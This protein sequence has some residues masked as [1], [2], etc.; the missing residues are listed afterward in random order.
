MF[1]YKY[2][3]IVFVVFFVIILIVY[4]LSGKVIEKNDNLLNNNVKF[5]G[6][7]TNLNVSR[8]HAFGILELKMIETNN[9]LFKSSLGDRIYPYAIK[10]SVAEIYHYIPLE[11][12][13]GY[14]VLL[15]SNN[16]TISFYDGNKFL[17]E[18]DISI[19][20]EG[21]D[22]EFVKKHSILE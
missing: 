2:T 5:S 14:K 17:Y 3:T 6:I 1:K 12:K 4:F 21:T 22:V 11:I 7:I 16:K 13:E 18:S 8:N 10:G 9:N 19:I 20:T 15:N